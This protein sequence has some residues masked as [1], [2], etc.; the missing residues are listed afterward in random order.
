MDPRLYEAVKSKNIDFI[1]NKAEDTEHPA[2][3]D[4]TPESNT[5]L[6]LAAASSDNR[7]F[8]QEILEIEPC[9][10]F[11]TEKNS[12]GDLPLHVAASAGN[13]QMV[14]L[15]AAS[16]PLIKEKNM[17]GNT[18][19]HLALIKKFQV[20]PNLALKAEYNEVVKF[21]VM[22]C[23]EVSFYPN[24]ECNC[25]LYL[26][27]EGGDEELMRHMITTNRLPNGK[28]CV[29]AAMYYLMSTTNKSIAHAA[30]YGSFTARKK[31]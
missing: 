29:H 26:A 23:P 25:P 20:G 7:Q 15:L 2:L 19:L 1:K 8:V 31:R 28:S 16:V 21:L 10:K 12:N 5:I 30:I 22:K 17:E 27:V 13:K 9:K 3:S 24:G 18:P 6:H 14:E 4:K 11:V